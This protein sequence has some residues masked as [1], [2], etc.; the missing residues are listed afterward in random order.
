MR[1]AEA[2]KQTSMRFTAFQLFWGSAATPRVEAGEA[3]KLT[4]ANIPNSLVLRR[5]K[6]LFNAQLTRSHLSTIVAD[7]L[8]SIT[9]ETCQVRRRYNDL[10]SSRVLTES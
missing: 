10:A 5:L 7:R 8:S 1:I 6:Q 3:V 9:L 4:L 2:C